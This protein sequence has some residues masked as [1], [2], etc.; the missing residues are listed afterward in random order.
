MKKE[1]AFWDNTITDSERIGFYDITTIYD[2]WHA[3]KLFSTKNTI[4]TRHQERISL[5]SKDHLLMTH[6]GIL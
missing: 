6:S 2:L 5:L 1:E 3:I 4:A